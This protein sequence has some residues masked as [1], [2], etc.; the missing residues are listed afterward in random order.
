MADMNFNITIYFRNGVSLQRSVPI[1]KALS[2]SMKENVLIEE[3]AEYATVRSV[4]GTIVIPLNMTFVIPASPEFRHI[5]KV[6]RYMLYKRDNGKCAYCG[7]AI[8]QKEATIDHILPKSQGGLTTWENVAL[9]CHRC[10]CK[11]DSRTPEQANMKLLIVPYNP[12]K[13]KESIRNG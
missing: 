3:G 11:K 2:L 7:K 1:D 9:A 12:K 8:S 10:N 13:K 4:H 6:S 5:D